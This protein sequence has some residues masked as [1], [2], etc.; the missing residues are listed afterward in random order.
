MLQFYCHH[1]FEIKSSL[2]SSEKLSS[3]VCSF[4]VSNLMA[5]PW[6]VKKKKKKQQKSSEYSSSPKGWRDDEG[7]EKRRRLFVFAAFVLHIEQGTDLVAHPCIRTLSIG[8]RVVW[9]RAR[10]TITVG[11]SL[12]HSAKYDQIFVSTEGQKWQDIK[13]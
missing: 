13:H 8:L 10:F 9:K 3:I 12:V 7:E 2:S 4:F 11:S 1:V 6:F 5:R